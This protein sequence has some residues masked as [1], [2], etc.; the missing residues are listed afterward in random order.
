[1]ASAIPTT[2]LGKPNAATTSM[3]SSARPQPAAR[4][5]GA[6]CS[7]RWR[8]HR[9]ASGSRRCP[10]VS[11]PYAVARKAGHGPTWA[12]VDASPRRIGAASRPYPAARL[13]GDASG[14]R[15][16]E[17]FD[18]ADRDAPDR[19]G[20]EPRPSRPNGVRVSGL[21][22]YFVS[23][24]GPRPSGPEPLADRRRSTLHSWRQSPPRPGARPPA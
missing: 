20:N 12:N 4:V 24:T 18:G 19:S 16:A 23:T 10:N 3:R 5:R 15:Q 2:S 11:E 1:M 21:V 17:P 22:T 7:V 8:C 9:R 14:Q 6:A 13:A